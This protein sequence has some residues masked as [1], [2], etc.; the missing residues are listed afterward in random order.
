MIS[1]AYYEEIF[2]NNLPKLA[3]IKRLIVSDFKSMESAFFEANS[4]RDI[5][6]MRAELH[7]IIP[8]V[9]NLKFYDMMA[10]VEKYKAY[11]EYSD[12]LEFFNAELKKCLVQIYDFINKELF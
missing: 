2:R 10:L 8:I 3:Q 12:E 9:S 4:N 11:E 6:L 7:K 5:K 1:L